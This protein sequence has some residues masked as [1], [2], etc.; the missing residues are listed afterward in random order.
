MTGWR[1]KTNDH[2]ARVARFIVRRP[3]WVIAACVLAVVSLASQLPN[4]RFDTTTE[5]FLHDDDPALIAYNAFRDQFGR[6]DLIVLALQP[7]QIFDLDFLVTLR[8]LHERLEA[9]VPHLDEVT[10]LIN[11]RATRGSEDELLVEDLLEEWPASPEDL[12]PL[13]AWV[14]SN[15]S[16]RNLLISEDGRFTTVAI[17]T[18]AYSDEAANAGDDL[19]AG[20]DDEAAAGEGG[21]EPSYLT[22]DEIGEVVAGVRAIAAEFRAPDFPIALAGSPVAMDV[23]KRNMRH[24]ML[25]FIRLTILAIAVLLVVVFRRAS[26]VFL[27]LVVVIFSLLS[28]LGLMAVSGAAVKLPTMVLPSFLLA[29]G[30]GDSVHILTLFFRSLDSGADKREA[31]VS[32]LEHSGLPVI[33]TSVTTAGGLLSFVST[34]L[35]PISDLGKFAPAGVMIALLLSLLLLPA[36]LVVV[37]VRRRKA[38]VAKGGARRSWIDGVIVAAGDL[39]TGKPWHVIG[40]WGLVLCVAGLGAARIDFSHNPLEWL[41]AS[42]P[43]RQATEL[44]DHEL[45][46]SVSMEVVLTRD[47]ENGWHDPGALRDLEAFSRK[48]E[49]YQND[50]FFVGRAFSLVDVLKEIHKALNANDS[51]YYD[52]PGDRE[53]I[54]QEFL[55]FENSG[56]D[57]LEDLVDSQFRQVRL[58][59]KGP[60]LDAGAYEGSL[61]DLESMLHEEMGDDTDIVMTGIVPLLTRTMYAVQIGIARSYGIAFVVITALMILL[62][63]SVRLGF[64]AMLPNLAPILCALGLM[65]WFGLPLDTFTMLIGSIALGLA[66]DDT[67]HFMHGYRRYLESGCDSRTAVHRTLDSAGR[68]MLLT[69]VVLSIG[70]LIFTLSSMSNIFNFGMLTAFAIAVALLADFLLAPALMQVIHGRRATGD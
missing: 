41:P 66:V 34:D 40:V 64:V 60:W 69:T 54:A 19:A 48:A 28:T 49:T 43:V 33:L 36:L 10:S 37:P 62:I 13:E 1:Q 17:R 58:S 26:A 16:Y 45:R 2:I 20:F 47:A 57:D 56:S 3:W 55:L 68:A 12:P 42:A 8:E 50:E 38:T 29:V 61:Q 4:I 6:D 39:A 44:I 7:P 32:A 18:S 5:G 52:V 65:G 63:G 67:I 31:I 23:V 9:E 35:A 14:R 25:L 70:F 51:R 22:D 21:A 46:G 15:P 53:L 11:A 30:V 27:P 59:L 24:D